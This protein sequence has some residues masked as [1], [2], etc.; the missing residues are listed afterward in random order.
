MEEQIL[1]Q[2]T[3]DKKA[4]RVFLIL[5]F[6][7]LALAIFLSFLGILKGNAKYAEKALQDA[8]IKNGVYTC[9]H[10]YCKPT[11]SSSTPAPSFASKAEFL[12][13]YK[14][15]HW[16]YNYTRFIGG[17]PFYCT[18]WTL[19]LFSGIT[20]I[21]Y[22]VRCKCH[23][24][25]TDKNAKGRTLFGKEV[26]LPV[27]MISAYSTKK[28]LSTIAITTASGI[29]KFSLIGNYQEIGEILQKLINERQDNTQ[30]AAPA[31]T[32]QNNNLDDLLKLKTL[33]DNGLI[34]QEEF[35]AKKKQILG[36]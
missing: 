1:I 16:G 19:L 36:L 31:P 22:G 8:I 14:S 24:I 25:I 9:D 20:A 29:T 5:I 11:W 7:F 10:Y 15:F 32:Q 6:T 34:T 30:M 17:L 18:S 3:L 21:I 27:H 35:D 12:K 33:L 2:S 13:H 26:V 28:F 4:K 23:L